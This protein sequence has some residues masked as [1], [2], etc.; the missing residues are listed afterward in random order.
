MH[1]IF[2]HPSFIDKI[3][4][5]LVGKQKLVC[6]DLQVI[7]IVKMHEVWF[8]KYYHSFKG[9]VLKGI[10]KSPKLG[11]WN[12]PLPQAP[13]LFWR[14]PKHAV[15]CWYPK[16]FFRNVWAAGQRRWLWTQSLGVLEMGLRDRMPSLWAALL[17]LRTIFPCLMTFT[18]VGP[19]H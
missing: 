8:Y 11:V 7:E 17:F 9:Y 15:I 18:Q 14:S 13:S 3:S 16:L 10:V 2:R 12:L 6:L 1:I 19:W 5:I 4:G